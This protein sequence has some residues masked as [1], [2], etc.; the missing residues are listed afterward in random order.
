MR[1]QLDEPS[2]RG[3]TAPALEYESLKDWL[4]LRI[5]ERSGVPA[6]EVDVHEPLGSF[7][8]SS[9]D[10]VTLSG[11]L[12]QRLGQRL[13]PVVVFDHPSIEELARH[14]AKRPAPPVLACEAH[15][16]PAASFLQ[17][18]E[19]WTDERVA[20]ALREEMRLCRTDPPWGG[21]T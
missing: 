11:D 16:G 6:V 14:L 4:I 17:E 2:T 7:G 12:E 20:R 19:D 21:E 1:E 10:V 15:G 18:E 3:V 8:I 13:S 5:A 9:V